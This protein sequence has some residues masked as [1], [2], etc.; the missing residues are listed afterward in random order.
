MFLT[1]FKGSIKNLNS[2]KPTADIVQEHISNLIIYCKFL[3]VFVK[4]AQRLC[5]NSLKSFLHIHHTNVQILKARF[6]AHGH[7]EG[8]A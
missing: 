5:P 8:H 2:G 7:A 3:Y 6:A 4:P 1:L